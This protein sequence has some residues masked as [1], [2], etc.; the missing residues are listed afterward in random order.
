MRTRKV[1]TETCLCFCLLAAEVISTGAHA[2]ETVPPPKAFGPVPTEGQMAWHKA[3]MIALICFGLNT[4]TD[5]EWGYGDVSPKIFN[6]TELDT[7]QWVAACKAGGINGII[8]VAKHHDGFCLWPSRHTEYSVK[9]T[10]WRDGKGDILGD[11]ARSCEKHDVMLGVYLSPWD[12]NHAE[13]ARPAYVEYFFNQWRE[14]MTDYGS[15]FEIWFDGANGGTGYYGGAREK[16]SIGP[17]YYRYSELME[18]RDKLQPKAVAFG[19]QR[20]NSTRWVGNESGVAKETNWCRHDSGADRGIGAENGTMW[21][22]AE[23]DTPFRG[24]WYWHEKEDPKSLDHLVETYFATVGRNS[25]LNF[26]IAPDRRGLL[27]EEDVV[28][29]RELGDYVRTMQAT[30]FARGR[31][32]ASAQTRGEA[33]CFAAA[34]V[35]DGCYDSYWATNDGVLRGDIEIDLGGPVTFNVVEAQE[36]VPLGQRVK[37]WSV[38]VQLDGQWREIGR[39]TTIGYKRVLRVPTTTASKARIRI[40]DALACPAI[41]NVSLYRAP[42]LMRDPVITRA[43]DGM[44]SIDAPEGATA[45]YAVG[46]EPLKKA[47]REYREP[48]ALREGGR[49]RAYIMRDNRGVRIQRVL[50][51]KERLL[52]SSSSL[53]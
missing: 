4:Y 42:V 48:F 24:G 26:G 43:P 21:M 30:D 27:E 22:P 1:I 10:P 6:P 5:Q 25:T 3:E 11:L 23:S 19:A 51:T 39:A 12:R 36:Y 32:V 7:D 37:A 16:R 38:E 14:V 18:L 44:V 40:L 46:N 28:R 20:A 17:N 53:Y 49:V 33:P 2:A 13:Y 31:K 35:T 45:F 41:N 8:L 50:G 52:K 47:F 9:A 34:N 29:L 15:L